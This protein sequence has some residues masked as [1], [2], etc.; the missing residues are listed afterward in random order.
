MIQR[1]L[2]IGAVLLAGLE[3]VAGC[4]SSDRPAE[5]SLSDV[6]ACE[7][8]PRSDFRKL[9]IVPEPQSLDPTPGVNTEGS[10]CLY[11]LRNGNSATLSAITNH[12]IDRWIDVSSEDA[13]FKDVPRIQG[14][15]TIQV[16]FTYD[17]AAPHHT[18]RLFVDVADGQSLKVSVGQNSE[19]DPP[20]CEAA[21]QFAETAMHTLVN[22][23]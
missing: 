6:K 10:S 7:L 2:R 9:H 5:L 14:Y 16:W 20:T 11:L 15:R 13:R 22:N 19:D 21:R 12:G 4:G 8:I 17:T 1:A 3:L 18:C 23:H